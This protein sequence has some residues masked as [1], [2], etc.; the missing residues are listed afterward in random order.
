VFFIRRRAAGS[1]VA[2]ETAEVEAGRDTKTGTTVTT[3]ADSVRPLLT[4]MKLFGLYFRR[5]T[6]ADD[7]VASVS[8]RRWSMHMIY[9]LVVTILL[10]INVTRMFSVFTNTPF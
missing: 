9:S 2:P 6:E 4:S 10:W 3:M 1:A 8:S 5:G 7:N